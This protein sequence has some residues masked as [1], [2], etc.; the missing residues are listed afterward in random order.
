MESAELIKHH[1]L[2]A[3]KY[4]LCNV[5]KGLDARRAENMFT[6]LFELS[7]H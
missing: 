5:R 2:R 3:R 1:F 4:T 7:E 6:I